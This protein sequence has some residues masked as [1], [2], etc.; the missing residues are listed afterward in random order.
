MNKRRFF[1]G[2]LTLIT[3]CLF[4]VSARAVFA[5]ETMTHIEGTVSFDDD[6]N[7]RGQRPDRVPIIVATRMADEP[8]YGDL[9]FGGTKTQKLCYV[10]DA[11]NWKYD[12]DIP[13]VDED[14]N[15]LVPVISVVY[16]P[17]AST[18]ELPPYAVTKNGYDFLMTYRPHT[19]DVN[20]VIKWDDANNAD[21]VRPS[22]LHGAIGYPGAGQSMAMTTLWRSQVENTASE[23]DCSFKNQKLYGQRFSY[24][25]RFGYDFSTCGTFANWNVSLDLGGTTLVNGSTVTDDNYSYTMT[26]HIDKDNVPSYEIIAVHQPKASGGTDTGSGT[27]TDNKPGGTIPDNQTPSG[28]VKPAAGENKDDEKKD[29]KT[30]PKSSQQNSALP[31]T[32]DTS[33]AA[34]LIFVVAGVMLTFLGVS[35]KRQ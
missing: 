4:L 21:H 19:F 12:A 5:D 34:T 23:T 7:S 14:G 15:A 25:D 28:Q 29:G 3:C 33:A 6:N 11:T 16:S 32:G 8:S 17:N 31:K 1:M 2:V 20:I 13:T 30:A 35:L 26:E 9:D 24:N 10:S 27:E 18:S 22:V